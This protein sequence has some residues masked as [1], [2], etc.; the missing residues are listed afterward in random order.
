MKWGL[1]SVLELQRRQSRVSWLSQN[2]R[3]GLCQGVSFFDLVYGF[4]RIK[5]LYLAVH[6]QLSKKRI[7]KSVSYKKTNIYDRQFGSYSHSYMAGKRVTI[8]AAI[9][10]GIW[11]LFLQLYGRQTGGYSRSYMVG[12]LAAIL[13][14]IWQANRWLFSQLY[15]RQTGGYSRSYITGNLAA[16]LTTIW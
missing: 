4:R 2:C 11:Q 9:W 10:Q 16:I 3:K 8:L 13:A 7:M 5:C 1:D 15:G 6:S 14:A 12:N